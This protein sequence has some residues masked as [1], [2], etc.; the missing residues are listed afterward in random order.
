MKVNIVSITK[1]RSQL[2]MATLPRLKSRVR[3]PSPAP[4]Y[5]STFKFL[6]QFSFD[7]N[8]AYKLIT[9]SILLFSK[10]NSLS[11]SLILYIL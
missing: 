4:N 8:V 7:Y 11:K 2:Y 3:I 1:G 10:L 6:T 9:L 5:N